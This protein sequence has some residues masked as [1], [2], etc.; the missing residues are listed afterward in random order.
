MTRPAVAIIM[1]V[2]LFS[3]PCVAQN[4]SDPAVEELRTIDENLGHR[5]DVLEKKIDD[6]LWFERVDD[7]AF[8]DKVYMYGP[9]LTR[10]RRGSS[11]RSR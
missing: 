11:C 9:P 5:L 4:T 10:Q 6:L 2:L 7:A 1:A 3:V 8:I